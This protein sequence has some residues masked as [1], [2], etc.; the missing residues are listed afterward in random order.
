MSSP[1]GKRIALATDKPKRLRI[2]K[3]ERAPYICTV[4]RNGIQAINCYPD[5]KAFTFRGRLF[6][7]SEEKE[8]L[9]CVSNQFKERQKWSIQINQL[10]METLESVINRLL[11][12]DGKKQNT[13]GHKNTRSLGIRR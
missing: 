9:I 6:G 5:A 11:R 2:K 3:V 10:N 7:Y 8:T 4:P 12:S 13:R 1:I